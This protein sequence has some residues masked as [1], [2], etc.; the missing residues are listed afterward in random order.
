M[1][2]MIGVCFVETAV[3]DRSP[4]VRFLYARESVV[5]GHILPQ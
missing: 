5:I 3:A 1:V 4:S 2:T